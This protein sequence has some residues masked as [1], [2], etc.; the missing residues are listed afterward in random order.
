MFIFKFCYNTLN[1]NQFLLVFVP[2]LLLKNINFDSFFFISFNF[3]NK[4]NQQK[5]LK[6]I[7]NW[8]PKVSLRIEIIE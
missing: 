2:A 4:V 1:N 7:L 8:D 5:I 6:A 3:I